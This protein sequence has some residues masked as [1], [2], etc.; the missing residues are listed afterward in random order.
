MFFV[1]LFLVVAVINAT[2]EAR[3]FKTNEALR[4]AL[5][6]LQAVKQQEA[7]EVSVGKYKTVTGYEKRRVDKCPVETEL[8]EAECKDAV[9][10]SGFDNYKRAGT[11][12]SETCGCYVDNWGGRYFNKLNRDSS[13][14]DRDWGENAICKKQVKVKCDA[15]NPYGF[16]KLEDNNCEY[17]LVFSGNQDCPSGYKKMNEARDENECKQILNNGRHS[18]EGRWEARSYKTRKIIAKKGCIVYKQTFGIGSKARDSY[19]GYWNIASADC[20]KSCDR[21]FARVCK[22]V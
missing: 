2:E 22:R 13:S 16:F 8:T 10:K 12:K 21:K 9:P 15:P 17:K 1:V 3:L 14:C 4:Q 18:W 19:T 6:E 5:Q 7:E 11:W 20:D